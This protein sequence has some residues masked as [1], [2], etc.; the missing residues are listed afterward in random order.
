MT[1]DQIIEKWNAE[2]DEHNQWDNLPVE[3]KIEWVY[4]TMQE[5]ISNLSFQLS[6]DRV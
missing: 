1:L 4:E 2:A 5:E 6:H 3:E